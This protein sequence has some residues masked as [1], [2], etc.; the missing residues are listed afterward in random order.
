MRGRYLVRN[1]ALN[2][3]LQAS[4]AFLSLG[5]RSPPEAPSRLPKRVLVCVGGHLG[6]AV[7]AT[8]AIAQLHRAL[9]G[10]E[11]GVLSGSWNRCVFAG[12]PAVRWFH[13]VDHWKTNRA[14]MGLAARWMA[15]R[16]SRSAAIR[17]IRSRTYDAAVDLYPYYPNFAPVISGARIPVRVG[18]ASGGF[19]PLHTH[20]LEWT[21]GRPIVDDHRKALQTLLPTFSWDSDAGYQLPPLGAGALQRARDK[22]AAFGIS[23]RGYVVIHAGVGT[24]HKQ[25]PVASW[26]AVARTLAERGFGVVLTGV[27]RDEATLTKAIEREAPHVVNLCDALSW[28]EYRAVVAQA[29]VVLSGDTVAM[30]VASAEGTP[31]VAVMSGID[32]EGRWEPKSATHRS[33]THTVA[34]APCFRSSGCDEMLCV[35]G[36]APESILNAAERHLTA[37]AR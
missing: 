11:V 37:L 22:L 26:V 31:S 32:Y 8:R 10:V 5:R 2:A 12:H 19:G 29:A 23:P 30:H 1:R 14:A 35:R 9:P 21:P 7:I 25:W 20:A 27:G 6:D 13:S 36:T 18:Y 24:R 28:D 3:W 34:C 33:L 15:Y 4:D 16:A 17:E